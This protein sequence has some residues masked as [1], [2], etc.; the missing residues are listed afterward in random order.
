MEHTDGVEAL[1]EHESVAGESTSAELQAPSDI[2]Q[3]MLATMNSMM[4]YQQEAQRQQILLQQ[5]EQFAQLGQHLNGRGI[6]RREMA[7]RL[8]QR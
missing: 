8:D 7:R 4:R 1:P 5:Q 6:P 3:Q 2:M